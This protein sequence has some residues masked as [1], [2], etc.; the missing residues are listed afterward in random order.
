MLRIIRQQFGRFE[1]SVRSQSDDVGEGSAAINPELPFAL[2]HRSEVS[3]IIEYHTFFPG[4]MGLLGRAEQEWI[5]F[6]EM[7]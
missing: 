2:R 3:G 5:V 7:K 1:L 6:S 4:I